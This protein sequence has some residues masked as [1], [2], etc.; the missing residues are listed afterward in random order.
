MGP[1]L[2]NESIG[3]ADVSR[4]FDRTDDR[5][6]TPAL[7]DA[8]PGASFHAF[9]VARQM[10]LELADPDDVHVAR[11]LTILPATGFHVHKD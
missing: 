3:P 11:H 4:C 5:H 10:R 1:P 2:G 6:N 9:Q 8:E 7:T